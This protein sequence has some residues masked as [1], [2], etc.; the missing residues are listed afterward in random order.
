M[1]PLEKLQTNLGPL[2]LIET[3]P[4]SMTE[5]NLSPLYICKGCAGQWD[6]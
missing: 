3:E 1:T 6:S 2:R 4:E 5:I